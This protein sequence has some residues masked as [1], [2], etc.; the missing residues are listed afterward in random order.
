MAYFFSGIDKWYESSY[1]ENTYHRR[2]KKATP[3][4]IMWNYRTSK[5]KKKFSKVTKKK[6]Q[7]IYKGMTINMTI[8]PIA[9]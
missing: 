5:S 2:K 8:F 3:R 4:Q 6:R 9:T 1:L 7:M